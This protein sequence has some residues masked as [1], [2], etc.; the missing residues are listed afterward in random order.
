MKK[1]AFS[2]LL[3]ML[4]ISSSLFAQDRYLDQVFTQVS[5]TTAIYGSNFTVLTLGVP[6]I[7]HTTRQPLVMDV[8]TPSGDTETARPLIL[9]CH[10]GNFLPWVDQTGK[11]INGAC[12]GLRTDSAAI[13]FCTRLAQMGYVVA[14]IDYRLGWRPDLT[15]ELQR[16]FTLINA[17]Y[18]GVQDVRTCIRYFRKT[19]AEQANPFG[20]D[21]NR[22]AVWGQ[23]TGGYLS[24]NTAA[25]DKYSEI[26]NTS[27]PGKF[28]VNGV[29]M[30]I[31]AYNGDPFGVQAAPGIVDATYAAIT[32]YPVGDT[33]YVQ[34]HPGYSSDFNLAINMGGALGDKNWLDANTPPILSYHVP[35]DPFAPCGEGTVIVPGFNYAVVNVSGSCSVQPIMETLNNN[36]VF[37]VGGLLTDALSVYART[38][39]GNIEGFYP[40]ARPADDSAPWE[41]N[42]YVPFTILP[43]GM[44]V[45]LDC[46]TNAATSRTTIDTIMEYF[47]PRG[48]R[49]LGLDCP[50]VSVSAENLYNAGAILQM[51]PNPAQSEVNFSS[52]S[53]HPMLAIELYDAAGRLVQN[54]RSV[55][56]NNFVLRRNGA[57]PGL[58]IAKVYFAEGVTARKLIF[59]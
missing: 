48:C 13:E 29:P 28:L 40:L 43:N 42:G 33:L 57:D 55:N 19:V 39:N 4:A 54:N 1:L 10:T 27:E 53:E 9:Y 21:P 18:R 37:E 46:S 14:S 2:L 38:I 50:G 17:A 41:W 7:L 34:N 51:M 36:D 59:E 3:V 12:G 45:N 52:D 22:I 15:E 8:Y 56:N 31:E 25:L 58:Y 47:A 11:S 16:R 35:A 20:I 24:L 49:G 44:Q 5:K 30:I 26:L 23:G 6:S 32:G